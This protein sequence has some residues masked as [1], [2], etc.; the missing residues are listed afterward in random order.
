MSYVNRITDLICECGHSWKEELQYDIERRWVSSKTD[1]LLANALTNC[2]KCG[3]KGLARGIIPDDGSR[4]KFFLKRKD[5]LYFPRGGWQPPS[6]MDIKPFMKPTEEL[7]IYLYRD[8]SSP[9]LNLERIASY[10]RKKLTNVSVELREPFFNEDFLSTENIREKLMKAKIHD[11]SNPKFKPSFSNPQ[12]LTLSEEEAYDGFKLLSAAKEKIEKMELNRRHAHIIFTSIF[13]G[14]WDEED[15][16]Y[17]LR[18]SSNGF[19]SLISTTGVVEAP[20]KP[21]EFYRKKRIEGREPPENEVNGKFLSNNDERLT[22]VMKGLSMQ[23]IFYHLTGEPFCT[24]PRCRLFNGHWQEEIIEAQTID[25]EFCNSHGQLLERINEKM[26][27][28]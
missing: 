26:E 1:G 8:S 23:T 15:M 18:L 28:S 16:R 24:N 5:S 27:I 14:T 11:F 21:R 10:L 13:F 9:V 19:P 2:S 12:T 6:K 17:H 7:K 3:Y 4:L 22:E 25:P 20:A